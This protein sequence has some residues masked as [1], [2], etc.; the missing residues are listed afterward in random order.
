MKVLLEELTKVFG[1]SGNED[2]IRAKII[3]EIR[4]YADSITVDKLG[5]LIATKI[6]PGEKL[7]LAA[8]MDEIGVIITNADEKGFLRFSNVGGV[9]PFTLIGQRVFFA[10]GTT[11]VFGMEKIDDIKDL[12]LNKMFIDIGAKSKEKALEKINIGE[13]G[14]YNRQF[15]DAGDHIISNSLDDR[16]GCAVLIKVLKELK[17]P[18]YNIF[19]VFTVQEEVGLRGAK[20]SA[21]GLEP[22]LAIAVDVTDTGDTPEASEIAVELGKGPAIKIKD[23]SVI[24]HPKVKKALIDAAA[25]RNIPFQLEVLEKGGTDTGA[26]HLTRSGVPSGALSIPTR[27]IHTPTEMANLNDIEQGVQ[28]LIELI[29]GR[30]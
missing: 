2:R 14:V 30:E 27:Y 29:E 12:K 25:R 11:G 9:S 5:N 20:T 28:L 22:D 17:A 19:V 4:P 26:I 8:H 23:S 13:M 3:D 6:G 1:P 7:M 18:N 16:A 15:S 10:N 21:Y 24:C